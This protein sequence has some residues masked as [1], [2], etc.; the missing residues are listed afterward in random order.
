MC[1]DGW[2]Q[3]TLTGGFEVAGAG[4]FLPAPEEAFRGAVWGT[5]GEHGD[6][7]LERCRAFIEKVV[8]QV[9]SSLSSVLNS[10]GAF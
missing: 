10:G 9:L 2:E 3:G 8:C 4:V 6:A 7:R 5:A 1:L